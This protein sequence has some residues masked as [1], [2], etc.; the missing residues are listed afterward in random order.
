MLNPMTSPVAST[1]IKQGTE[2]KLNSYP[3]TF[4]LK[5]LLKQTNKHILEVIGEFRALGHKLSLGTN[6]KCY[7]FPHYN[8]VLVGWFCTV[9]GQWTRFGLIT[10]T[11]II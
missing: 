3:V 10:Y 5:L 4:S 2:H 1:S 11:D 9:S 8:S 7:T 6:N